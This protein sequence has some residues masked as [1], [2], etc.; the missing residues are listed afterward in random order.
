MSSGDV[1]VD[2]LVERTDIDVSITSTLKRGTGTRD[3]DN[4]L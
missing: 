4:T 2:Q 3:E 1:D